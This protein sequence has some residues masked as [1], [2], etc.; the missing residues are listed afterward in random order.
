VRAAGLLG[1]VRASFAVAAIVVVAFALYATLAASV[2]SPRVF[3]DELLYLEAAASFAGGD[4]LGVRGEAYEYAPLY[5]LL[6]SGVLRL[7]PDR[8]TAYEV[9]KILNAL[10]FALAAVPIY[11]LARRLLGPW[12][13]V[14]AGAI[15]LAIPSATY[16]SFVMTESL[17]FL[18]CSWALLA[19][20]LALERPTAGRQCAALGAIAVC[21]G[22]RMQLALLVG[23]YVVALALVAALVPERRPSARSLARLWPTGAALAAGTAALAVRW[24]QGSAE[25][26][27]G[28]YSVLWRDYDP[29]DVAGWLV[30][31]LANL[32]LYVAVVPVAVAPIVLASCVGRARRGSE[33]DAAF[34]ALFATANAAFLLVAAAFNSTVFAADTLHDRPVFYVVPLWIV[35]L[36]VWVARGAPRPHAVA[37]AGAALAVALP[38]LLPFSDYARDDPRVQLNAAATGLWAALGEVVDGAGV[39][40]AAVAGGFALLLALAA[41]VLPSRLVYLV[42]VAVLAVLAVETELGWAGSARFAGPWATLARPDPMWVDRAVAGNG[43]V[44]MLT[45]GACGDPEVRTAFFVTEFFN[46][47]IHRAVHVGPLPE[48]LPSERVRIDRS[49]RVATA[50]NAPVRLGYVVAP[51]GIRLDGALVAEGSSVGLAL[52]RVDGPV[53]VGDRRSIAALNGA[54]RT[55]SG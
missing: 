47:S 13:S 34:V 20:V 55:A 41:L 28:A 46:A 16:V 14:A 24:A 54:C 2:G 19:I 12:P 39:P 8:E 49:G 11:L 27:L 31:Q 29:V 37:A 42:P 6:L 10:L 23:V 38:L 35:V 15:S 4:G 26:V 17:A 21:T 45:T 44:T 52:W 40:A 1:R 50:S 3:T 7:A 18:A 9:A 25:S 51:P 53:R 32:D 22:V 43:D 48:A 36:L 5:P 30:L 33:R